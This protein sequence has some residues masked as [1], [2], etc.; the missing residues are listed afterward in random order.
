MRA[1]T[2][3]DTLRKNNEFFSFDWR[4]QRPVRLAEGVELIPIFEMFNTFKT[5]NNINP[6]VTHELVHN[7]REIKKIVVTPEGDGA[8]AVVDVDTLWRDREGGPAR[9]I[10][11]WAASGK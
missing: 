5:E 11:R 7:R 8:F 6:L 3:R 1:A 10:R 2:N 9:S 4:P